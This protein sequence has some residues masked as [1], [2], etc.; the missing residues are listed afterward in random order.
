[1]SEVVEMVDY[2][3]RRKPKL[4]RMTITQ[5]LETMQHQADDEYGGDIQD[6]ILPI[7]THLSKDDKKT[8]LRKSLMFH[9]ENQINRARDGKLDVF[10]DDMVVDQFSID[11][12]RSAIELD[13][14]RE[15]V[16]MKNRL[17]QIFLFIIMLAFIG[18]VAM[19]FILGPDQDKGLKLLEHL[20]A[21][22]KFILSM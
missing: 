17:A 16:K 10:V 14:Y 3:E 8:F 4:P 9:W 19:T 6:N 7:F 2:V 18:M 20:D 21:I 13:N 5:I 22:L 12:E 1:M 11:N 15:Q